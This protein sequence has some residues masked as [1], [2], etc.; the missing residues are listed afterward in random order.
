M[1]KIPAHGE[2]RSLGRNEVLVAGHLQVL[3]VDGALRPV[4]LPRDEWWKLSP[5]WQSVSFLYSEGSGVR[6]VGR[7][8]ATRLDLTVRV[9]QRYLP[10]GVHPPES[11]FVLT[12]DGHRFAAVP[13]PVTARFHDRP[14]TDTV[15]LEVLAP[16]AVITFDGLPEGDKVIEIWLPQGAV[17][18]LVSLGADAPVTADD[19]PARPLWVHYGS[20]IS[21]CVEA[22]TPLDVWPVVAA[23]ACDLDVVNLGFRGA[24][25]LEPFVADALAA[26]PAD[27]I[28]LK[29]GI[30][31][32]GGRTMSDR[33]FVPSLHGFLDRLR[34]SRP[35]VPIVL[36]S[37]IAW[38]GSED[39]PGPSGPAV[40]SDGVTRQRAIG[41][42]AEVAGG[43]LTL[44]RTRDLVRHVA[45]VRRARGDDIRY[46]DGRE[47][48]GPADAVT[49][50][51]P[52][53]LHPSSASYVEM[54]R[55]FARVVFAEHGLVPRCSLG[56]PGPEENES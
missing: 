11:A 10:D 40:G 21:H 5:G 46:L 9:T 49:A 35:N 51:L 16:D 2:V 4:R 24:C 20:S 34:Q 27:V 18:D 8:T 13:T 36:V 52:D 45:E 7:T 54:G 55:R 31:L 32:V 56:A 43:A 15:N 33:T 47:L 26:L 1:K 29:V 53:G 39:A 44:A 14:M 3:E 48:Y 6:V 41:P 23:R 19:L 37:P 22:E 28:S 12:V 38:P 42:V 30:N 17:T 50:P 25:M